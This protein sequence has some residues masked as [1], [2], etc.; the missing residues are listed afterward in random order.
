MTALFI[1]TNHAR[2]ATLGTLGVETPP[3]WCEV[4][5]EPEAIH[6]L[7][8]GARCFGVF[9][10][11]PGPSEIAWDQRK[12]RGG[13]IGIDAADCERITNWRQKHGAAA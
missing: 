5:T 12:R 1:V 4:V 8:D 13:T 3:D 9:F 10:G 11:Q 6:S 2:R 7:P